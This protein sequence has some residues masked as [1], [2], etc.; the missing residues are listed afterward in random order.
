MCS[1]LM[2]EKFL[3]LTDWEATMARPTKRLP[4]HKLAK[5]ADVLAADGHADH[6]PSA[7][8]LATWQVVGGV[9][10]PKYRSLRG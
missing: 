7:A 9:L 2:S 1:S 6:P 4:I 5:V 3:P 8:E 10:L